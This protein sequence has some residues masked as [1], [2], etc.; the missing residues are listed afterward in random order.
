MSLYNRFMDIRR[1]Q[2]GDGPSFIALVRAL[3]AFEQL[4]PPDEHAEARLLVDAFAD[5]PR[6][7]LWVADD[8]GEVVAYAVT[9][10]TYSTFRALPSLH[11]EDLFV[12]PDRRRRGVA[13]AMLARLRDEARA[14]GCGRFEWMVLDWNKDAKKLYQ[15]V[16]AELSTQWHLCRVS[17]PDPS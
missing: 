4:P 7:Q 11:L 9:F 15:R 5:P 12:H 16:G 1:A 6:Y 3:A 14:Q 2:P 13:S 17:L 10:T 8:A